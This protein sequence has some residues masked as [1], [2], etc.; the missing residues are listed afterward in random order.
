M[1]KTEV[2]HFRDMPTVTKIGEIPTG[3]YVLR[4]NLPFNLR[5]L[6]QRGIQSAF[7]RST[8]SKS[9]ATF[10]EEELLQLKTIR[11]TLKQKIENAHPSLRKRIGISIT[12]RLN[13]GFKDNL[14]FVKDIP[15]L[16][17][18]MAKLGISD[19]PLIAFSIPL[20]NPKP[21]WALFIKK[22]EAFICVQI[23]S[24][25]YVDFNFD[26][27]Q[28]LRATNE[29]LQSLNAFICE[30]VEKQGSWLSCK[31]ANPREAKTDG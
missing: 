31:V 25:K 23:G 19:L 12:T 11:E 20:E 6:A 22:K 18:D 27:L 26:D 8:T 15:K 3:I 28:A 5:H 9:V 1:T 2:E 4:I 24:Q 13:F 10:L 16:Y 7:I 14:A 21:M 17:E 30:T 29:I